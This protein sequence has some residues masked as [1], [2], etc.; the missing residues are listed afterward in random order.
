MF[1]IGPDEFLLIVVV[2]VIVIGP[3]DLPRA[4][5]AAGK[6]IGKMRSPAIS[7]PASTR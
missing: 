5:R 7:A 2:A 6:W 1:D 3:K 4:L